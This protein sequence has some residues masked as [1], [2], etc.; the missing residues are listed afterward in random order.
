MRTIIKQ[1][2]VSSENRLYACA[3]GTRHLKIYAEIEN[4][5]KYTELIDGEW[6]AFLTRLK[7]N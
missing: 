2:S 3:V 4:T 1:V 6:L 5:L 7:Q